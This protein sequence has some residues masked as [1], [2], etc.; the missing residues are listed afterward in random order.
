VLVQRGGSCAAFRPLAVACRAIAARNGK[1]KSGANTEL[2]A[3]GQLYIHTGA[4]A[5]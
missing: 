2:L 3:A 5:A 4:H 1:N